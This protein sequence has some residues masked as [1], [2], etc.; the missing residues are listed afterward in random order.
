[1]KKLLVATGNPHK[2]REM[3]EGLKAL[4]LDPLS[5]EDEGITLEQPESGDTYRANALIKAREAHRR[6]GRAAL[7]DDSGLEVDALGGDPGVHS[8][9][10]VGPEATASEQNDHL[11]AELEGVP[12]EKRGARYVCEM[13]LVDER[14]L[15]HASRGE[16]HGRI[17]AAPRGEGG[18]GYDPVFEVRERDWATFAELS[19]ETKEE[20]SHRARALRRMLD[21][22]RRSGRVEG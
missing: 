4:G 18:F 12:S 14:G 15:R 1:M 6:T 16:V 13:V 22:L 11:L 3:R 10:W 7:A 8:D 2:F 20:I 9:R 19:G 21:T 5:L 17:A